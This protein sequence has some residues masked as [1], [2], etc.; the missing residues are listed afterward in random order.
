MANKKCDALS[1]AKEQG[2][3]FYTTGKPC[4]RGHISPRLVSTHGCV[5]CNTEVY[6]PKDRDNY[7][8]GNTFYRQFMSRKQKA[9]KSGIPFT[10]EFSDIHQPEFC[11]V[12]GV[13][14]NYGWSG[15][16]MRDNNKATLDKVVPSLGYIPGNVFVISWRA[17]KLKSDMNVEELEKIMNYI[18]GVTN[19]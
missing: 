11:P 3:M 5:Q 7:R 19:G 2:D 6:Y 18:R 8:Y 13:K 9:I 16:S 10:I 4:K 1:I 15:D 12:F 14:L 17:N